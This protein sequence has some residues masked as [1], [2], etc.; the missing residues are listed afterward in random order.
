MATTYYTDIQKLY[1]AYF[2]RPADAAGLAYYEGVLEAANGNATTMAQLSADFAKSTEYTAAFQGK[3]NE[4]IVDIIYTNLFGHAADAAGRKYYADGLTAGAVS[5]A[6]VVQDVAF[7]AQGT[8]KTAYNNKLIAAAAFTAAL[9][10]DAEKAGYSGAKANDVAKQ[11]LAKVTDDASLATA[12]SPAALNGSVGAAVAAGT[13]FSVPA[14]LSQLNAADK[15]MTTFVESVDVDGKPATVT[16]ASDIVQAEA[17]AVTKVAADL[18]SSPAAASL[19]ASTTSDT[20]RAA[21]ISEQQAVNA[22]ALTAAQAE[23]TTANANAAKVAGL[24]AAQTT[25][26]SA[27]TAQTAAVKAA[28]TAQADEAA[29]TAS[30]GVTNGGTAAFNG[31]ALTLKATATGTVTTL[32]TIDATTG[33]AKIASGITASNYAGLTELIASYNASVAADANV[34]KANTNVFY[35]TLAVNMSDIAADTA[36][37]IVVTGQ[38]AMTEKALVAAIAA[39]INKITPS[40]VAADAT[41]TVAQIQTALAVA[42]ADPAKAGNFTTLTNLVNAEVAG[43][44]SASTSAQGDLDLAQSALDQAE[45]DL[46]AAKGQLATAESALTTANGSV[47]TAQGNLTTANNAV[48]PA[49]TAATT[50]QNAYNAADTNFENANGGTVAVASGEIVFTPTGGGAAVVLAKIDATTGLATVEGGL[51]AAYAGQAAN[52][53]TL[54]NADV[55]AD[56]AVITAQNNVNSAQL[57]LTNAQIAAGN[58]QDVVNDAT[59]AADD[60]QIA[61]DDAQADFDAAQD[62]FDAVNVEFNPLTAAQ[63]EATADVKAVND[64]IAKLTK[65]VA[66]LKTA[67]GNADALAGY[68]A[69][70]DA[71]VKFL[72]DN[73]YVVANLDAGAATQFATAD[74]DIF[75]AGDKSVSIA[76]FGLQ[77]NDSVFVGTGYTLVKGAIGATG[78]KGSDTA[79]EIFLSTN[80]SGDAQLQIEN[81]AYSSAVAGTTGEIVTITLVGIDATTLGLS[82]DG[83]ITAGT[84]SA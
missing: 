3:T 6:K 75:V 76:A 53:A 36:G 42:K 25:L 26:T 56:K 55:N 14:A 17:T 19:F 79:M 11:F 9:D 73:G 39:E 78:I 22:K 46:A 21:L 82:T 10:T 71:A 31:N 49:T 37:T 65:D 77:G 52:L 1:V 32:A 80:A 60:A 34:V 68:K 50:A 47:T 57:A 54:F 44:S 20:V 58:A 45:S 51:N 7:G 5:V 66:A 63:T 24:S 61:F 64:A 8:D 83:I 23:L 16:K 69:T 2:N 81:H 40:T 29:K 74:S 70:Y 38:P 35:A 62:A 28:Q 48:A 15:S 33:V 13:T 30:F 67:E 41:P 12:I 43:V 84:A 4:Q 59:I 27:T 72:D 18:T